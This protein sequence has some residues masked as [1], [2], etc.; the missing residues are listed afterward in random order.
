[1]SVVNII[2]SIL[3]LINFILIYKSYKLNKS[4]KVKNSDKEGR[5][6]YTIPIELSKKNIT[7]ENM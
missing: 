7:L 3:V 1:M 5:N 6:G 2:I 4:E